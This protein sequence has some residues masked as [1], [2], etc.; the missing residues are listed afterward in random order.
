MPASTMPYLAGPVGYAPA[1]PPVA[2]KKRRWQP[3]A[4]IAVILILVAA[5]AVQAVQISHLSGRLASNN[6]AANARIAR[7]ETSST[8]VRA[9][10]AGQMNSEK[11]AATADASVF[12]VEAGDEIGSSW[13]VAHPSGGGT[14]LVTNFHVIATIFNAGS[15]TVKLVHKTEEFS[16][17]IKRTDKSADLALLH[18][19]ANYPV[20]AVSRTAVVGEPV[21]AVGEPLGLRDTVTAG[22]VSALDRKLPGA[23]TDNA[24]IQF[25][26]SINPGNSGG[27]VVNAK[28]QVLGIASD[29]ITSAEGLGFAIPVSI[30]CTDLKTC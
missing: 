30:A 17:T 26:A 6:R 16:A 24:F 4:L 13:A 8:Q 28:V 12:E 25:D 2:K 14:D 11:V 18:M 27:P 19:S 21:V 22:V 9:Q 7:L 3:Y 1:P 15:H 20:L 29:G 10:I 23:N 5:V